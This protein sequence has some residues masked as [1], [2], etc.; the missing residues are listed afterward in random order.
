M[1][2][3]SVI[4]PRL[5]NGIVNVDSPHFIY[6]INIAAFLINRGTIRMT[7]FLSSLTFLLILALRFFSVTFSLI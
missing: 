1:I 5:E 4:L 7:G 2:S 3:G 6:A